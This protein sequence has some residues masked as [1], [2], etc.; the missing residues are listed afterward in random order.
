[1]AFVGVE[2]HGWSPTSW[3]WPPLACNHVHKP[4][5]GVETYDVAGVPVRMTTP[6]R[7]IVDAFRRDDCMPL[8]IAIES[9]R[10]GF[11]QQVVDAPQLM[12]MAHHPGCAA[13]LQPYVAALCA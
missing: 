12:D 2:P 10:M 9:L 1:M 5:I 8:D 11:E 7:S 3:A 6:V 13:R 4:E